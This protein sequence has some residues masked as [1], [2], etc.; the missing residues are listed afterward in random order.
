MYFTKVY[1][2]VT[3]QGQNAWSVNYTMVHFNPKP[4]YPVLT[5]AAEYIRSN[6]YVISDVMIK[7]KHRVTGTHVKSRY[8]Q[9]NYVYN[10]DVA[11]IAPAPKSNWK[12]SDWN[13]MRLHKD[14][15]KVAFVE[16]VKKENAVLHK[17]I[18]QGLGAYY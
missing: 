17:K 18:I 1:N 2:N 16:K 13:K 10:P 9:V 11:G 12:S 15:Q 14:P 8:L 3:R 5:E 6:G 4:K 7:A